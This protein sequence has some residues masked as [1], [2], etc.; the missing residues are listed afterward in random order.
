M[1]PAGLLLLLLRRVLGV[2]AMLHGTERRV[3]AAV[4]PHERRSEHDTLAEP[5]AVLNTASFAAFS[6]GAGLTTYLVARHGDLSLWLE[7]VLAIASGVSSNPPN[8]LGRPAF[9]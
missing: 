2:Y 6:V 4:A 9:G 7:I 1:I 3:R 5:S 8:A